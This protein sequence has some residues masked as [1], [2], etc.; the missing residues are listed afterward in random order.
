ML[1][2]AIGCNLR[3][4]TIKL[5]KENPVFRPKFFWRLVFGPNLEIFLD[6]ILGTLA[7]KS[8]AKVPKVARKIKIGY[9]ESSKTRKN[10]TLPR[11]FIYSE[12]Y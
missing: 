4:R 9:P 5:S 2:G 7:A 8:L 10:W 3:L 6:E 1:D 12:D 11:P